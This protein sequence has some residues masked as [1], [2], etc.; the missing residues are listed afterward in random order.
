MYECNN[1]HHM[2]E[3]TKVPRR[4]FPKFSSTSNPHLA[5]MGHQVR[6][7]DSHTCTG[8]PS[9]RPVHYKSPQVHKGLVE[10]QIHHPKHRTPHPKYQLH[11]PKYQIHHPKYQMQ[12]PKYQ[13]HHSKYQ[14]HQ[15]KHQIHHPNY[16]I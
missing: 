14:T 11:H 2:T 16:Q 6:R 8:N 5:Q 4:P 1:Y 10:D 7:V 9:V 3:R 13:I 12:K 15:P